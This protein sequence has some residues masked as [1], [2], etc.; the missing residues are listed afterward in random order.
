MAKRAFM[1]TLATDTCTE[2]VTEITD[3]LIGRMIMVTRDAQP[4]FT[5][6]LVR[7]TTQDGSRTGFALN[8][9]NILTAEGPLPEVGNLLLLDRY[10]DNEKVDFKASPALE[11]IA[12]LEIPTN[13]EIYSVEVR[14]NIGHVISQ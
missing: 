4:Q 14:G 7:Y 6:N 9:P 3:D 8:E 12:G 10:M 5:G 11:P 13:T 1:E 2:T